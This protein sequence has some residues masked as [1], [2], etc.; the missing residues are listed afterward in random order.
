MS[1]T[2]R[3]IR[4]LVVAA[5]VLTVTGCQN[6]G[7][8]GNVLGGVLNPGGQQQQGGEVYGEV[9]AIDTQRQVLQIQTNNGQVGNVYF[10]NRT[11]VVYQQREYPVTALEQGDQIGLRVQQTQQGA[12]YT[13]YIFV[14][15]SVQERGGQGGGDGGYG[16]GMTVLEGRVGA[17]DYNRG[18][19]QLSTNRGTVVVY[20]RYGASAAD[21]DRLRRLR[22]GDYVRVEGRLTSN[23]RFELERFY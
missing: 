22:N 2:M 6:L 23:S 9:R 19:F 17:V 1:K 7:G 13:D 20:M 12:A 15:Q 14:T 5:S 4:G 11:K 3:G 10:D 8:L 16:T 18:E 21:A